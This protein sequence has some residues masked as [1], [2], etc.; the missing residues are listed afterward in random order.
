MG[1]PQSPSNWQPVVVKVRAAGALDTSFGVGGF[2]Y[3]YQGAFGPGGKA[4]DLSIQA[5]GR[6]LVGGRV[7]EIILRLVEYSSMAGPF[8]PFGPRRSGILPRCRSL[9]HPW[10]GGVPACPSVDS[11]SRRHAD[12]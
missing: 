8:G 6:V 9:R 10:L 11:R 5:D 4:T 3:F 7:R 2:S 12:I 1:N